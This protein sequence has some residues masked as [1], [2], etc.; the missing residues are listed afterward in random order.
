M[1]P[2]YEIS[3]P[4]LTKKLIEYIIVCLLVLVMLLKESLDGFFFSFTC[5]KVPFQRR[6]SNVTTALLSRPRRGH[7]IFTQFAPLLQDCGRRRV[8]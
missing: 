5:I 6:D 3:Y 1:N 7:L 2:S 8:V 4:Q